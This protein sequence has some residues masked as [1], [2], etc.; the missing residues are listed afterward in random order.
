[1]KRTNITK[2][3]DSFKESVTGDELS[4]CTPYA[5]L[6]SKQNP[7]GIWQKRF[8]YLNNEF[9]VYKEAENKPEIKG[10]VD[11]NK[12]KSVSEKNLII[13]VRTISKFIHI[14]RNKE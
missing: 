5:A 10:A 7:Y 1:M 6:L 8:V 4:S 12:A 13:T 11:L 14:I 2:P 3:Q 9:L